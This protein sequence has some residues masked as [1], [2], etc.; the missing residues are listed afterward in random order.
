MTGRARLPPPRGRRWLEPVG[1]P[2]HHPYR[3][4][5]NGP[6]YRRPW[7]LTDRGTLG[8]AVLITCAAGLGLAHLV[9]P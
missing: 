3:D 4:A 7:P 6:L 8:L 5:A 9:L 1:R 2:W